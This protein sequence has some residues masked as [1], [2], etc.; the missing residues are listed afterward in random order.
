MFAKLPWNQLLILIKKELHYEL[1]SRN[2]FQFKDNFAFLCNFPQKMCLIIFARIL[3]QIC[4]S[5][6]STLLQRKEIPHSHPLLSISLSVQ[7]LCTD[8]E[9]VL[10]PNSGPGLALVLSRT[11]QFHCWVLSS[12]WCWLFGLY[13]DRHYSHCP[14]EMD[15]SIVQ[16]SLQSIGFPKIFHFQ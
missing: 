1:I 4:L 2:I 3:N 13:S 9:K 8:T 14:L 7:Y 6:L 16:E 12:H 15:K 11:L 5:F 10:C